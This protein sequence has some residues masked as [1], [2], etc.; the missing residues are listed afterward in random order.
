MFSTSLVAHPD[1]KAPDNSSW[2]NAKWWNEGKLEVPR[3][4]DVISRETS[5]MNGDIEVPVTIYRPKQKGKFAGVLFVHGRPGLVDDIR[6]LAVRIA[7][8]GFIV[9]APDL[10]FGRDID[11]RPIKHDYILEQDLS[12][13]LDHM[14]T[15]KDISGDKVCSYS[16][17]RGGYYSL[18]LAVTHKRQ[19]DR[20]ACYVSYYPHWQ[21]P[22]AA[23]PL[24]VYSY[25]QELDDLK[26]PTLVF[27]G[28]EEQYQRRRSIETAT[29]NMLMKKRPVQLV[30]Y[31]GVQ[32]GFDFRPERVRLFADDLA[33]K[34]AVMRAA[35]FIRLHLGVK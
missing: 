19:D 32:R 29:E 21:D 7:A 15:L 34:D 28:D 23:E 14:M 2:W 4:Y 5:Y 12:K 3:N 8:R 20:L 1:N 27:Y 17:T 6:R 31:P 9:Y 11:P 24:Q 35:R 18:K 13:G 16:H 30:V 33:S 26:I 25:A 10:Y 22:N